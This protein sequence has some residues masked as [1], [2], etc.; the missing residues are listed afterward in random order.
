[1]VL[2]NDIEGIAK[3]ADIHIQ[4]E[5][6]AEIT[7]QFNQIL[8][9]LDVLDTVSEGEEGEADLVNVLRE[10]VVTPSLTQKAASA[11]AHE[12]EDGHIRAPRVM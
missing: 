9:Y 3:L 11:N 8:E 2:E 1:M 4:K 12:T 10:D 7:A 5:E 6:L